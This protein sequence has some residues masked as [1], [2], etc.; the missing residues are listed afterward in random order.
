MESSAEALVA[1]IE[2]SRAPLVRLYRSV[3]VTELLTPALSNGWSVKDLLGHI[4]AWEWKGANQLAEARQSEAPLQTDYDVDAVNQANYEAQKEWDWEKAESNFNQAHEAMLEAIRR[5][6]PARL[7]DELVQ[8][9]IAWETWEHYAE[10]LP[11]LEQWHQRV[12]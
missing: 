8:Q 10:H 2:A 7:G 4:A 3:P 12:T 5:L 9:V 1:K 6:P 11:E